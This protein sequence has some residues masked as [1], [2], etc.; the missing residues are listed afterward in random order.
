MGHKTVSDEYIVKID[1]H[2]Q[3]FIHEE[4]QVIFG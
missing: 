1:D 3:R 2:N 4:T